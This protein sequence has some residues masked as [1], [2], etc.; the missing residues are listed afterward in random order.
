ML[1][2]SFEFLFLF[3]P[4]AIAGYYLACRWR[5]GLVPKI[6]LIGASLVF[7]GWWNPLY[8]PLLL[9]S[10]LF[11]FFIALAI[12]RY[13]PRQQPGKRKA[14]FVA[15]LLC[16]LAL[17]AYFK[18][19][20]FLL[21]NFNLL[22]GQ[23]L[24]LAKVI[25]PLGISFFTI[26][27]IAYLVDVYEEL[28]E[29]KNFTHYA[30]FVTF[31]PHLIAGPI[32]HHKQ[33]TP[34]FANP[35]MQQFQSRNFAV[36]WFLFSVGLFKKVV[37]ADFLADP[38]NQAYAL[39]QGAISSVDAWLAGFGYYFQLYFDFS[40][41]VDMALGLSLMLNIVL[42]K[43]FDSPLRATSI[44]NFWERWHITLSKFISTYIYAPMVRAFPGRVTFAKSM[45]AVLVAM[46][47]SGLWHGAAWTYVLFGLAHGVA[48]VI[49]HAW[50]YKKWPMAPWLGGVLTFL[51]VSFSLVIFRSPQLA[52]TLAIWQA[53]LGLQQHG[54]AWWTSRVIY[55]GSAP[56]MPL[57][58]LWLVLGALMAVCLWTKN[59]GTY[60]ERFQFTPR[61]LLW[62]LFLFVAPL[63][64]LDGVSTFV[65]FQ[66]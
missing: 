44:I 11:N 26:Q 5:P 49:N 46:L 54:A 39:A 16:N 41:Y 20:N 31:F 36:G 22:S 14:V 28:A 64:M 66:F 10:L 23:E 19:A 35:A 53:M 37:I 59:S 47:V 25:L 9:G 52:D 40:G 33:M 27:Q 18:Y 2:S 17:L 42:P 48:L 30:L 38:V 62:H 12:L 56:W 15:G 58:T 13:P 4:L 43:N 57:A 55:I 61:W 50:R 60:G 34:Q 24:S 63:F 7:Y 51:F 45:V 3:M 21:D 65:Y 29:E 6:W 32:L 1:F 8:L